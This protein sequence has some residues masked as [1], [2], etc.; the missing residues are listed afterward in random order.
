MVAKTIAALD[1]ADVDEGGKQNKLKTF[2]KSFTI[3]DE[4]K[5]TMGQRCPLW[6][7]LKSLR[8]R[9]LPK[10]FA[11]SF[12]L[13]IQM[14]IRHPLNKG[15]NIFQDTVQYHFIE[16]YLFLCLFFFYLFV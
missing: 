14:Y 9:H 6:M 1:T 2:W 4:I 3:L 16:F 15:I 7:S 11:S 10:E 8:R 12:P 13:N 5:T